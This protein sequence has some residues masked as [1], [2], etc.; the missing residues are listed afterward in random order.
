VSDALFFLPSILSEVT[1]I[2]GFTEWMVDLVDWV[3]QTFC[4]PPTKFIQA[5]AIDAARGKVL[6]FSRFEPIPAKWADVLTFDT[7]T[8]KINEMAKVWNDKWALDN[9]P[10]PPASCHPGGTPSASRASR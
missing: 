5:T 7:T 10:G 8:C 1:T 2:E 3:T 9:D 4:A 6:I